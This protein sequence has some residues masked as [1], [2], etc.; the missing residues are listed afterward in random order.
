MERK[1]DRIQVLR[2]RFFKLLKQKHCCNREIGVPVKN[3]TLHCIQAALLAEPV[4]ISI[5]TSVTLLTQK[6][7]FSMFLFIW[8][9]WV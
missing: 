7:F 5:L 6:V 4:R 2:F 3:F 9:L 1:P 8:K